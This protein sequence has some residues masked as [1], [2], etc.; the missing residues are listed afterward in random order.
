[1]LDGNAFGG[2]FDPI[3]FIGEDFSIVARLSTAGEAGSTATASW[4]GE[5][6][7]VFETATAVP[8]PGTLP[9]ALV[10]L[11]GLAGISVLRKRKSPSKDV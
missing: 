1:M 4:S 11:G 9:N 6:S 10:G 5:V 7:V 8:L 3:D 2:T